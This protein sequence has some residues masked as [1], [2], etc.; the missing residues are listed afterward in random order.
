M[1]GERTRYEADRQA[2]AEA[3]ARIAPIL[4]KYEAGLITTS[5]LAEYVARHA[6]V[7]EVML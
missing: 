6:Y 3:R 2:E 7:T 1:Y 4:A 5:E